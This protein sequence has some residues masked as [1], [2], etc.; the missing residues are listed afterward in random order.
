MSLPEH[1]P[2]DRLSKEALFRYQ[3][4]SQVLSCMQTGASRGA[5]TLRAAEALHATLDGKTRRTSVRT[6]QRWLKAYEAAGLAGLERCKRAHNEGSKA[7]PQVFLDFVARQKTEEDRDA[8]IPELIERAGELGILDPKVPIVRSTVWRAAKRRGIPLSRRKRGPN[9]GDMRRF[10]YPHRMQMLL[11]DGKHFRAGAERRKR[12]ALFFLD[13]ATRFGLHVVV[14]TS[15]TAALFLRGVYETLRKHGLPD[16]CFVDNGPGFIARDTVE[17]MARLEVSLI[18]GTAGYPQGH[19]KIEAFNKTAKARVL[20]GLNHRSDVETSCGALELRLLHYMEERYNH[21]PHEAL[22]GATPAQRFDQDPRPL[23]FHEDDADLRSRFVVTIERRVT[24]DHTVSVASVDY[25][26]PRGHAG[27]KT[28]VYRRVLEN[29]L[30]VVHE[31]HLV[32]IA[33]V[34]LA[35]N[36]RDSRGNQQENTLENQTTPLPRS[37]ASIAFER[38]LPPLTGPDGGFVGPL[39]SI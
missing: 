17:V 8:S 3:V 29:T 26:V 38:D 21:T 25:E 39:A 36:A 13:D 30:H 23:R 6:I 24:A 31:G 14:G 22:D 28:L 35:R 16:A 2:P 5:C 4:L 7:V 12:V 19:G 20:R 27:E 37:A 18:H 9:Q 15:E 1:E 32:R 34:D 33:P 11:C 10:A